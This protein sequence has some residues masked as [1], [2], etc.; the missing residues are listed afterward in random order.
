MDLDGCGWQKRRRGLAFGGPRRKRANKR[1]IGIF[2]AKLQPGSGTQHI[3]M[4][5]GQSRKKNVKENL[6]PNSVM[7]KMD[8]TT[9]K[10]RWAAGI[11]SEQR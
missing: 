5:A 2:T 3:L 4:D 9:H 8:G 7:P 11:W 6:Q 1:E 10:E